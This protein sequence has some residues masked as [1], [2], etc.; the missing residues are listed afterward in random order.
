MTLVSGELHILQIVETLKQ[1]K[2][3]RW[4]F[5]PRRLEVRLNT[6]VQMD[7]VVCL[8][9]QQEHV[10]VTG[11]GVEMYLLALLLVGK[12]CIYL[13]FIITAIW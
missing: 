5:L 12:N 8:T 9:V 2:G 11:N 4:L 7:T 10:K 6:R 13:R 1:P 3:Q